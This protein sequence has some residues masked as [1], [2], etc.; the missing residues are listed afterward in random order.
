MNICAKLITSASLLLAMPSLVL[1]ATLGAD[2]VE[3]AK[4]QIGVTILYDPKYET[5]AFPG[6]DVKSNTG[7]CTDVI[8]RALRK[9]RKLDLQKEINVDMRA[10]RSA[11]PNKWAASIGKTDSNI[12]HR[13]VPNQMK[14]FERLGASLPV[15]KTYANYLPGDIVAWNLGTG[16]LH[17]GI[18][19]NT[20]TPQGRPFAI[21]NIGQGALD[22][23]ILERWEI[24]GHYRLNEKRL[25]EKKK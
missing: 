16:Q 14:Y 4:S 5:I 1:S 10:H 20:K 9:A 21:H 18:I 2:I 22:E 6:G 13:R 11:Y 15:T 25:N 24:I 8:I 3:A 12:D 17:I 7:V 19:S 23:D